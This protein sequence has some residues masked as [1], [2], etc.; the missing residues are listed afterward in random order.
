MT[1]P[2]F[3]TSSLVHG[4]PIGQGAHSFQAHT[5]AGQPLPGSFQAATPEQVKLAVEAASA[6]FPSYSSLSGAA[7][8]AFLRAIA[9]ELEADAGAIVTRA[10]QETALPEPR[11]RGELARTANQLR[12]FAAV[13]EEG[14]WVDAR[15]DRPD[16]ARTPPKPDVRSMLIP[17]GP[18]AVFGASNFP[19]AF[20]VA[21][22]DTASALAAGCPVVVKAH[23]AHPGTSALA[24]AAVVRAAQSCHVPAGVFALLQS[25]GVEVGQQLARH[26]AIQAIG[27][28]GSRAGGLALMR[29]AQERPVPIPVYAE[30]SSVNP[31]VF[32]QAALEARAAQIVPALAASIAGS[33]G[34]LCT[35]P[36]LLFVPEGEVGDAFLQTLA[37]QL[38]DVP[39]CTLLTAGIRSAYGQGRGALE[40]HAETRP[41]TAAA[42]DAPEVPAA[43]YQ[44]PL[45]VFSTDPSL[46]HEVFGPLSLAVRYRDVGELTA[47]LAGLE[48][49][50]TATLHAEP[51]ELG[52]LRGLLDA[53]RSRAGRLIL[54][55]FPT[56]VE[57]G[58]AMVHGGPYPATGDGR[59]SSVGTRAIT[60]FTRPLCWQDFPDA[61]LP[62]ELQAA[63]PLGL[64][65][66]LD[67]VLSREAL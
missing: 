51:D 61:A 67:G 46:S 35:Q 29:A 5:P 6:A 36:G 20:S 44:V 11:L 48:G 15:L 16:P 66:Q 53:L 18:V 45:D 37:A 19:L 3:P 56:G 64:W 8:G 41:L 13:A 30:M 34:Q 43:L 25:D 32:T 47:V 40:A 17:L 31:L 4:Q 10:M 2:S 50:L 58:H 27:F 28:T 7:R 65:R 55:G 49:Q 62:P 33:G 54:N 24:G 1:E 42:S 59:S 57:V 23:P 38:A 14:S 12:L 9:A 60:R 52:R 26:P 63:N 22:G 21:G 39:A